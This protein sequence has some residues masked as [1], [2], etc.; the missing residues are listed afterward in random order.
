MKKFIFTVIFIIII[1]FLFSTILFN[2]M[3]NYDFDKIHKYN[4]MINYSENYKIKINPLSDTELQSNKN[5]QLLYQN[6]QNGKTFIFVVKAGNNFSL[7]NGLFIQNAYIEKEIG[8]NSK[9]IKKEI[10]ITRPG[11]ISVYPKMKESIYIDTFGCINFMKPNNHY[12]IFCEKEE[13]SDALKIPQYRI[14]PSLYSILNI[15]QDDSDCVSNSE[16]KTFVTDE[17]TQDSLVAPYNNCINREF[18][19]SSQKTLNVFL[20]IKNDILKK[21][22]IR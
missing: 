22:N 16:K 14:T 10:E 12:L 6:S 9:S 17:Y 1:Y 5:K 19:T 8:G 15:D 7:K 21:Y 4:D 20:S 18:M 3:P 2:S 13:I 11:G